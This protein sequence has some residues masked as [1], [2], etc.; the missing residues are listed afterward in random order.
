M[1]ETV[2]RRRAPL[3]RS[4]LAAA[5]FAAAVAVVAAV[6]GVAASGSGAVYAGLEL[7]AWAPPAWL[8]GPVWT[9]LYVVIALA[10]WL[11]W[12]A[13]GLPG[14]PAFF[15][16]YA[17]Q[18]VLNAAWTPLFFGAGLY[19]AALADIAALAVAVAAAIAL[20]RRHS[21]AAA[22]M[23]VPYLL[24]VLFAAALNL[25]IAVAN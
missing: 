16:V 23:L 9:A 7:P 5:G 24:W 18:L 13:S 25:A 11:V 2:E 15:T 1:E 21:T 22:L 12:R 14:A 10:G 6:G 20:G 17:L 8:F 4:V 19:A 3:G